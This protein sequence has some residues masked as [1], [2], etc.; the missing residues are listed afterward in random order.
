MDA[1]RVQTAAIA[2]REISFDSMMR[3]PGTS[4]RA[5]LTSASATRLADTGLYFPGANQPIRLAITSPRR[6]SL[7]SPRSNDGRTIVTLR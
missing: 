1:V 2:A 6:N 3:M 4:S 5:A 7:R